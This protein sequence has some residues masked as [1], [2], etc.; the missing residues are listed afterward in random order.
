L[1]AFDE[2]EDPLEPEWA[3]LLTELFDWP[4]EFEEFKWDPECPFIIG[5]LPPVPFMPVKLPP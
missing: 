4:L 1:L 5:G 2:F 3:L